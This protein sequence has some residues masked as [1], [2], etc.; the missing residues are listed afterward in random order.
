MGD[1]YYCKSSS[2]V[3]DARCAKLKVLSEPVHNG[4]LESIKGLITCGNRYKKVLDERN[5]SAADREG[6]I[7][8]EISQLQVSIRQCKADLFQNLSLIHI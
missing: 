1:C 4:V 8:K 7:R 2:S 6:K 5:G 3:I